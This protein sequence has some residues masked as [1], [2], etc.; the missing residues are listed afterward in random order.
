[1]NSHNISVELWMEWPW[2]SIKV[3]RS[4]EYLRKWQWVV[5]R[6]Q[7]VLHE[8]LF[9]VIE[10]ICISYTLHS[11]QKWRHDH[12]NIILLQTIDA[13]YQLQMKDLLKEVV[14]RQWPPWPHDLCPTQVHLTAWPLPYRSSTV[15]PFS[16]H[17]LSNACLLNVVSYQLHV[18]SFL[19]YFSCLFVVGW[20]CMSCLNSCFCL[21]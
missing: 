19:L 3:F 15:Y 16:Y 4:P 12:N 14:F 11:F 8:L 6:D 21:S 20:T 17:V 1:M 7:E 13:T 5:P 2:G 18:C 9:S 10:P